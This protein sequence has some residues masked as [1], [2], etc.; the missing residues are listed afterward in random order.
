MGVGLMQSGGELDGFSIG[1]VPAGV[2][3]L[4]TDFEYEWEEVAFRSRVWERRL[5]DGAHRVDLQVIVMR[6]ERLTTPTEL[7]A[8]LTEYEERD[9]GDLDEFQDTGFIGTRE[10]FWLAEPGVA[11]VV[12]IDP[13][14]FGADDLRAVALGV[15]RH[16]VGTPQK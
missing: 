4:V 8:F 16:R 3:K 13:D 7:R 11:A 2:G 9:L 10:A 15:R 14:R 1:H 12:K 5:D 6:G